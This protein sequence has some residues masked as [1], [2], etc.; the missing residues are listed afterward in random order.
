M[1]VHLRSTVFDGVVTITI[2]GDSI[3]ETFD[4]EAAIKAAMEQMLNLKDHDLACTS[5]TDIQGANGKY[6]FHEGGVRGHNDSR[7]TNPANL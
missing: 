5:I 1:K 2:A 4:Y 6:F 3:E 7:R